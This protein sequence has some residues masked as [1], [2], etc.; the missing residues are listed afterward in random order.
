LLGKFKEHI[1]LWIVLAVQQ[2]SLSLGVCRP[3]FQFDS[4]NSELAEAKGDTQT[5]ADIIGQKK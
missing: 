2:I 5:A 1:R 3:Y 4:K